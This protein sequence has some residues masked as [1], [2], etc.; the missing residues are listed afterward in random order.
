MLK[1][2]K[3]DLIMKKRNFLSCIGLCSLALFAWGQAKAQQSQTA[4]IIRG[5]VQPVNQADISTELVS[6]VADVPFR[7][8]ERFSKGDL[9]LAFNCSREHAELRAAKAS[10]RAALIDW[11]NKRELLTYKAIG[12]NEVKLAEAAFAEARAR[13]DSLKIQTDHCSVVAP[14]GGRIVERS[15]N[16]HEMSNNGEPLLRIISDS[17]LEL[18]LIVPSTWLVWLK[19]GQTF[20]FAIDEIGKTYLASVSQISAAVD[21]VSQ[22]IKIKGVF[23]RPESSVLSGMSGTATFHKSDS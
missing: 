18:D 22:T 23:K 5:V 17:Q 12:K 20:D 13:T 8:G 1:S 4:S 10:S 21:P 19:P 11:K 7:E 15:I 3:T 2:T 14:F 6:L 9:L 16:P